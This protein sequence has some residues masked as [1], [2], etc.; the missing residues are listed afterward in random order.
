MTW[1]A[2]PW[3]VLITTDSATRM[4]IVVAAELIGLAVLGLPAAPCCA[5]SAPGGR[6]S[7]A[8]RRARR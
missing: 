1:L 6:W 8:T 4:S 2:L 7:S 3:F 5:G